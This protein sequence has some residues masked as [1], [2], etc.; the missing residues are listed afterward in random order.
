MTTPSDIK[1]CQ[2]YLE[3]LAAYEGGT[4]FADPPENAAGMLEE[5][6]WLVDSVAALHNQFDQLNIPRQFSDTC[7]QEMTLDMRLAYLTG[8]YNIPRKLPERKDLYEY[9]CRAIGDIIEWKEIP[10]MPYN[11]PNDEAMQRDM[12]FVLDN[13]KSTGPIEVRWNRKGSLQGH[14]VS[15]Q[16]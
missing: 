14:Y 15:S 2:G 3:Q 6:T 8:L 4:I 1:R 7:A 5:L 11:A 10:P 13:L 12:Q 16:E 9:R